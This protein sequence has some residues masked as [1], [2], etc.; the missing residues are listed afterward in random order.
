MIPI[1]IKFGINLTSFA[2]GN[3]LVSLRPANNRGAR[4]FT[5]M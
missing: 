3:P 1:Y 4:E 5:R 2:G